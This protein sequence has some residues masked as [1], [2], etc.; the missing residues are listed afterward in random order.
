VHRARKPLRKRG[1]KPLEAGRRQREQAGPVVGAVE[2]HDPRLPGDEQT[3]SQGELDRVLPR[4]G[5]Q[6]L[7]AALPEPPAQ[8]GGDIGLGKVAERMDA[9]LG[10]LGDRGNN[11]R[12]SVSERGDAEPPGEVDVLAAVRVHDTAAF[13]LGPDHGFNRLSVSTAI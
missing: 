6:H 4:H 8:L 11:I 1:A 13:R 12:I 10:L 5:E 2:G 9:P 7:A 3:R